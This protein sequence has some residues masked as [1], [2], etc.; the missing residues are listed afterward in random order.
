YINERAPLNG[1]KI[2]D[3]GCG[4]GILSESMA[5]LG[6]HVTA[7]DMSV[8]AIEIAKL[9]QMESGTH[10]EYSVSTAE[11]MADK[12]P[13]T[14]DIVTCLELLEHVPKPW[15]IVESCK[16]LLKPQGHLFFS[17]INRN[18]KSYLFAIIGAEYILKLLPKNTHDFA[19]FIKPSELSEWVRK[20]KMHV[21][22]MKGL[23]YNPLTEHFKL[24]D[25]VSVNYLMHVT[26]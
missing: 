18:M 20:S 19:K 5:K 10:V 22:D 16:K 7:I 1:K 25:D 23:H 21:S 3:I 26:N 6:G 8:D 9:H 13:G 15:R 14:F 11:S 24:N 2:L 4:G 12:F 17:T